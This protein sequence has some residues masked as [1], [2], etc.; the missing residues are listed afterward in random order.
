MNIWKIVH[1]TEMK[2]WLF[3]QCWNQN[4]RG[5]LP[6][7]L[8]EFFEKYESNRILL[9][10]LHKC[11]FK[12]SKKI[13]NVIKGGEIML[14]EEH[15]HITVEKKVYEQLKLYS[16][17]TGIKMYKVTS[18]AIKEYIENHPVKDDEQIEDLI[19]TV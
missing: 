17:I 18:E 13:Y 2:K 5:F 8:Y 10:L 14:L 12:K 9:N 6:L 11:Y 15:K 1:S 3:K 4:K 7:F 19:K 16:Q